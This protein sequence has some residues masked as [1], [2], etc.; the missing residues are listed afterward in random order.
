VAS[1]CFLGDFSKIL[2]GTRTG[3]KIEVS[4]EAYDAFTRLHIL[5]RGYGR[6][7]FTFTQPKHL[8]RLIGI[9]P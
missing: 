5:V 1:T 4:R 2:V 8:A 7:D 3:F 6:F 9:I